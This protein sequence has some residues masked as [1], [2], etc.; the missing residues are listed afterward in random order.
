MTEPVE[1]ER[2]RADAEKLG[3]KLVKAPKQKY[4]PLKPCPVCG[5]KNTSVWHGSF[6]TMQIR[7]QA[8]KCNEC[9]FEGM[10]GLN[11]TG[12]RQGWNYAVDLYLD[13][14]REE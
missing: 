4:I 11:E 9:G 2:L 3:Y 5:K 10:P 12:S 1:L 7:G 8:R 13:R 14:H 6:G